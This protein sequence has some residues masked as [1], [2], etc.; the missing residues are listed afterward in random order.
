MLHDPHH[1]DSATLDFLVRLR[2]GSV[3]SAH[4]LSEVLQHLPSASFDFVFIDPAVFTDARKWLDD[5][6]S[7][8][9]GQALTEEDQ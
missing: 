7:K 9:E 8:L 1:P 5:N 4:S 6:Q 3:T 2:D